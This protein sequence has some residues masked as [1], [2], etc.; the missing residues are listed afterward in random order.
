MQ[1]KTL[2]VLAV[3][4]ALAVLALAL[5]TRRGAPAAADGP[6]PFY[7]KKPLTAPEQVLYHRLVAALPGHIVLAQV[8]VCRVLGARSMTAQRV[9]TEV[10][11]D[12]RTPGTPAATPKCRNRQ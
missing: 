8:Q 4:V 10:P 7:A 11:G 6:W 2:L 12:S 3:L 9:E 5:L 1:W